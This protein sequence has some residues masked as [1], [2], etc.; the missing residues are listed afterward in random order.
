[1][2]K[3]SI[4]KLLRIPSVYPWGGGLT[5]SPDG[6]RAA[7]NW[8]KSGSW[9]IWLV[10]L[11]GR[12]RPKKITSGLESK[13][14][15]RFSPDG[16]KLAFL[17]D[18][19]GDENFDVHLYDLATGETRNAM[20]NTPD[21]LYE[22][23]SWSPD[24]QHIALISN[25][26]GRFAV[27]ALD[28]ATGELRRLIDHPY[29]DTDVAWSPDGKRIALAANT[30]GQ[31]TNIFVISSSGGQAQVLAD[32]TGP[33]DAAMPRWS[34]DGKQLAFVGYA[35]GNAD[36]GV[37]DLESGEIDWVSSEKWDEEYPAWSPDGGSIVHTV[38]RDGDVSLVVV[39]LRS[40]RRKKFAVEPGCHVDPCFTADGGSVVCAFH[41]ARRP[42][43]L[44][45]LTLQSGKW[46][47]LTWSAPADVKPGDFVLPQ[48][49]RW[50]APDGLT[51]PG[52]LFEPKGKAKRRPAI[53]YIHGGP[54][55]QTMIAWSP[56]IQTWLAEGW[57]VLCP[58]YRGSTGYGKEFQT[59][60]RFVLGQADIADIVAGADFLIRKG[61]ADPERIGIT[62][63]SYGGYMTM[64]GLTRYPDRFAAGSAVVPFLNWFTEFASERED[65]QYWDLQNMGD[66][67][68]VPD[69]FREASPAFFL[70]RIA[71]PVQMLAGAHDP[72]CPAAETEEATH[73]LKRLGKV[74]ETII[75]PDEGHGFLKL[76][77]KLT[78]YQRQ[79]R[80][81]KKHL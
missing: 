27:H 52:L 49:V 7:V 81:L 28:V 22:N 67:E 69:R 17:Q 24:G 51:I 59:A 37:W 20:P 70:D 36:I 56:L 74:H 55:W 54:A 80:F 39:N 43:D 61:L 79:M 47:Q 33:L 11:D 50:K 30:K 3:H 23:Y 76:K 38:N 65:L 71:A 42:A 34:P 6:R 77:N 57:A 16:S 41:N 40:G 18:F 35:G 63:A 26:G 48:P 25:R 58:N 10:S 64:V 19:E 2:P 8:N 45:K 73:E 44:W 68:K 9:E 4:S 66:P 62:G 53:L 78:A 5:V 31:D 29:S 46:T 75:F 1:M 72:R 15:P 60:N 13:S 12:K 14:A 32:E 21:A